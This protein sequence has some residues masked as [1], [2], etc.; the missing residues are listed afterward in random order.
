M[1]TKSYHRNSI[2][3]GILWLFFIGFLVSCSSEKG[4]ENQEEIAETSPKTESTIPVIRKNDLKITEV[5]PKEVSNYASISGRVVPKNST[6]L[7]AEVQGRIMEGVKPFKAGNHFDAGQT[8]LQ[9]DSREFTLNLEAQ[10][11]AFLNILTAM[12]PDLKADYPD[13]YEQWLGYIQKYRS[14]DPLP[15]LPETKSESER[16]FVT[17]NEIYTTYFSIKAQEE[18]L[19]KYT[20]SAPFNGSI[21]DALVDKGG[22][23]NPGQALGTYISDRSFEIEAGASLRL[24]ELLK[25]GQEIEFFSRELNRSF[26]AHVSR[27]NNIVDPSTQNIPVY[28]SVTD[29]ALKSG[30]YLEGK[31][32]LNG[33]E[34]AVTINKVLLTRDENVHILNENTIIKKEVD[35]LFATRD[36]IVVAGLKSGDQLI[37][38]IFDRPVAGLKI[39]N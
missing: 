39:A 33:Y 15:K 38:E 32:R 1:Y 6:Q 2:A 27:K 10:K 12:M 36:S 9:I 18:R 14:G 4:V 17:S 8:L 11:S 23:V 31:V 34:N 16:Y 26:T 25:I 20:I 29:P 21:S 19:T 3:R 35:V 30:M 13:N 22:L 7:V 28:L 24:G 37:T 5:K